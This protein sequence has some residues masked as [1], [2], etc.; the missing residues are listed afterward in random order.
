MYTL[1][2]VSQIVEQTEI[3]YYFYF[4]QIISSVSGIDFIEWFGDTYE[5]W[6]F[7]FINRMFILMKYPPRCF[8]PYLWRWT[9]KIEFS[10]IQYTIDDQNRYSSKPKKNVKTMESNKR[11]RI[12]SAP[13]SVRYFLKHFHSFIF[14]DNYSTINLNRISIASVQIKQSQ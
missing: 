4:K 8:I 2:L 3:Q 11:V 13:K 12:S 5:Q 10:L 1:K 9:W 7:L 6:A 14:E